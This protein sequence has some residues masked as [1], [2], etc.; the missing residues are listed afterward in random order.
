[1]LIWLWV[2]PNS[3]LF[4]QVATD[5]EGDALAQKSAEDHA[6]QVSLCVCVCVCVCVYVSA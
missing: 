5:G 1:M 4:S 2:K 3:S 6:E